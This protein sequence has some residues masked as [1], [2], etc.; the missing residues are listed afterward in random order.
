MSVG[1]CPLHLEEG[2]ASMTTISGMTEWQSYEKR[3]GKRTGV[4]RQCCN[5]LLEVGQG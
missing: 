3:E 5:W 2:Y 1:Q 4:E